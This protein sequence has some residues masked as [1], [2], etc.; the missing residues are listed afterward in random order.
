MLLLLLL[1]LLPHTPHQHLLL[2]FWQGIPA[3]ASA[4]LL[5]ADVS[6]CPPKNC[7]QCPLARRNFRAPLFRGLPGRGP[8]RALL[9]SPA[10]EKLA[11][12]EDGKERSGEYFIAQLGGIQRWM[13]KGRFYD[14]HR[15][16]QKEG[17][18]LLLLRVLLLQTK[19]GHTL[20]GRPFLENIRVRY[21]REIAVFA[22]LAS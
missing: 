7:L 20:L 12:V 4:F 10:Q 8:P 9:S 18:R 13:E 3:A 22:Q 14:V 17:G 19:E 6:S 5:F 2:S 11:L 21:G 16:H 1:L 15:V